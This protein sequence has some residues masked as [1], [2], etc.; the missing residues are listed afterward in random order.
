MTGPPPLH[1]LRVVWLF[2]LNVT[3][4]MSLNSPSGGH[5]RPTHMSILSANGIFDRYFF[6]E[7]FHLMA[8]ANL[9]VYLW[10]LLFDIHP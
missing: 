7:T 6:N 5:Y 9:L 8:R 1:A 3:V 10:V 4:E 2:Y